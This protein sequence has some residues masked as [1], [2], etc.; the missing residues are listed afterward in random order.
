MSRRAL[1]LSTLSLAVGITLTTSG[2]ATAQDDSA[3]IAPATA[4]SQFFT[5]KLMGAN[6]VPPAD[7]ADTGSAIVRITGTQVC[8]ALKWA[9]ISAPFAAHI[10]NAV[11][12]AAGPIVVPFFGVPAGGTLPANLNAVA[13]C[14]ASDQ[15]TVD[16]IEANPAAFYVNMHTVEFKAGALRGQLMRAGRLD[17]G[18][19]LFHG[20]LAAVATGAHEVPGPGSPDARSVARFDVKTDSVDFAAFWTAFPMPTAAHIHLGTPAIA[21]PVIVPLFAQAGGL[22]ASIMAV[23]GTM[24]APAAVLQDIRDNP[25]A[26]YYNIHNAQFPAGGARGQLFRR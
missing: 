9:H 23:A 8:F 26:F 11:A 20:N 4:A 17:L 18:S 3:G 13:G 24:T 22:P 16:A 7:P 2:V 12:G 19:M 5:A 15:A 25:R 1:L 10:H 6:E 14:V 21:G